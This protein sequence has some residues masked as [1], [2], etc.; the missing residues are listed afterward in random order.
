MIT[1]NLQKGIEISNSAANTFIGNLVADNTN[2]GARIS[3]NSGGGPHVFSRNYFIN[4]TLT[5]EDAASNEWDL[6]QVGNYWDDLASNPSFPPHYQIDADS[7][8][9]YPIG[10]TH[11]R[12]P[13][14][15]SPESAP[16]S[17]P[18]V[19]PQP[20]SLEITV[21][22]SIAGGSAS[23][24]EDYSGSVSPIVFASGEALHTIDLTVVNDSLDESDETLV[25]QF[26]TVS[27]G[28]LGSLASHE[29]TILD[30]DTTPDATGLTITQTQINDSTSEL[31]ANY[32][33][34]DIDGTPEVSRSIWWY[35]N[36]FHQPAHND[37]TSIQVTVGDDWYFEG[38]VS[39]GTNL[40]PV[41]QSPPTTAAV[42]VALSILSTD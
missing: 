3:S 14:S 27:N 1:G 37:Q 22:W 33:Y 7:I 5:A 2:Y 20:S 4:S 39:D 40:S 30:D 16:L 35:R 23:S 8:D 19:L 15:A 29:Y 18:V 11:F 38:Q 26:D 21:T 6:N 13:Q 34:E 31:T 25:V 36:T 41:R 17:L 9:H 12:E 28:A 24:P 10:V 32:T 42:P